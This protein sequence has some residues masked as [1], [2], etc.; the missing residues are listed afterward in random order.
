MGLALGRG[1][2]RQV[3]AVKNR[4]PDSGVWLHDCPYRSARFERQVCDVP[5]P[6]DCRG[7]GPAIDPKPK[8][9]NVCSEVMATV[10]ER[11]SPAA[12]SRTSAPTLPRQT[13]ALRYA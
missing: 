5:P 6:L 4:W 8:F 1:L 7:P 11:F 3:V 13:S 10:G 9:A 12:R 2:G